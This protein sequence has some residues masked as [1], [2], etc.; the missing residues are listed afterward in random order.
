MSTRPDAHLSI[1]PTV[2]TTCHIVRMP[3]RPKHH[4]SGRRGL[5]SGPSSVSRSFCSSLHLSGHLS[6]PSGRLSVIDQASDFPSKSKY[7]KITATVRTTWIRTRYSL[8]QVR[9]SNST[10]MEI[11]CRRSTVWTAIPHGL[12]VRTLIWKLLA[13]N[14]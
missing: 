12:D 5:S 10:D 14:V 9:N 1:V 4:P 2:R 3:D 13:V 8:R 11:V 6:S 7:G